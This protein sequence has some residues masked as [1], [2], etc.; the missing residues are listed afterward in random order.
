MKRPS[1]HLSKRGNQ[2]RVLLKG[3]SHWGN[4]KAR[5]ALMVSYRVAGGCAQY[6]RQP[7]QP[8]Q[9]RGRLLSRGLSLPN[10]LAA[11]RKLQLV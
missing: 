7:R 6:S 8:S 1:R 10:Q 3:E 5:Q 11:L 9:R 2:S 4:L